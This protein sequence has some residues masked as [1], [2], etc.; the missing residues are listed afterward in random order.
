MGRGSA[1]PAALAA[2]LG[3][4]LAGWLG[5][6]RDATLTLALLMVAA[7]IVATMRPR[8]WIWLALVALMVLTL[9][10]EWGKRLPDGL[11]GQDLT[12]E[13]RVLHVQR[14][15]GG[16]QRLRLAVEAC[17]SPESLLPCDRL[18]QVRVSA[19]SAFPSS[20]TQSSAVYAVGERW[21][22]T[23][24]LRPPRGFANPNSFDYAQWLWREGI[25][26]TGYVRN[27]PAPERLSEAPF[28]LRQQAVDYLESTAPEARTQR[29]LAALTLGD[30]DQLTQQ[31]WALLNATG[32]THL[33]VISGLHVGLVASFALLLARLAAR[34]MSP[35][36]WRLRVWPWWVAGAAAVG[37]ALLAGLA[38]PAMR[39]MIMTLLGLWVLSG[40]HAPGPWQAW[41]L[42]LAVIVV[43]D[44][45]SLWRPGLW[46]SFVA[47]GWL[48]V[49]WQGR[50]RPRGIKGWC[51]AL[52]RSQLLLAPLMA[53]A[54]LLAFGRVAPAAPLVNLL[55]VPWVSSIMVPSALLGWLLAPLPGIGL[56]AWWVF[57][58]ALAL[59]HYLLEASLALAPLWQPPH[60]HVYPLALA[61]L[62]L[63]L[64]WGLPATPSGVRILVTLLALS[65]P[66]W[67]SERVEER[68]LVVTVHDV[69]QGQLVELR[70]AGYRM[71]YDTG[72][73]F[74]SGFMPLQTLWPP[75][76]AFDLVVVSHADTDHAGGVEALRD[77]H[78]VAGWRAPLDEPLI[79]A[80][81][82]CEQGQQWQQEGI[83]YRF[84]WPPAGHQQ[85]SSNDRSCVLEVQVGEHRLLITGD[86][87]RQVERH[88]LPLLA[89]DATVLVAGHHG[90]HTSSG[91]QFVR[92]AMPRH[93]IFSAGR[94]NA[95]QHPADEVVRRFRR[96]HSCLWSTAHD[97]AV[98][99]RL[100]PGVPVQIDTQ[101]RVPGGQKRC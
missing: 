19:Y 74:R 61:W 58:Q 14:E 26:A 80:S 25:H 84:L 33:V 43:A 64:G 17:R 46:L 75:G 15:D 91:V 3:G 4:A 78:Q 94:D 60:E 67:P 70:S 62:L 100:E 31:D 41:W 76:Q 77:E 92:E 93:A 81:T 40:R 45:L 37:Y 83:I 99:I 36:D 68:R 44:P 2:L 6:E 7:V 59:F 22:L 87:G 73:R 49:I 51:W 20:A 57:A 32:T 9:Q 18:K 48:I 101:R 53:A 42:A 56:A 97:G 82:P 13:A 30:S 47:V 85:L 35:G 38:P 5:A 89:G 11:S 21:Q 98:R 28:Q 96:Q 27:D 10:L 88:L 72:P 55:A 12:L 54:V 34:L 90:S 66:W 50:P 16:S 71:L 52:L 39:A 29:W 79:V 24:R 65:A 8:W 69:G 1:V 63:A 23:V 86:V 95:F